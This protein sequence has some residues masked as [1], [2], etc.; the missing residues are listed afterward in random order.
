MYVN[1]V[2]QLVFCSMDSWSS[3]SG[4]VVNV[5]STCQRGNQIKARI[6]FEKAVRSIEMCSADIIILLRLVL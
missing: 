5:S 1:K 6:R 2:S 4:R 3:D